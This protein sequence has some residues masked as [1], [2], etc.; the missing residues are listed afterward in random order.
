MLIRDSSAILV[1]V[2]KHDPGE[3]PEAAAER[4]LNVKQYL[5][6]EKGINPS[7]IEVRTGESTGRSVD[8]VLVPAGA[9]WDT[10][11]TASFDPSRIQRH[12]QPYAPAPAPKK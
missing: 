11:G 5:T 12:G 3:K 4:T 1:V 6:D 8:N 10:G 2:G 9:S 7:R